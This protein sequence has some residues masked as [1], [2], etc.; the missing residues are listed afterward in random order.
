MP[1]MPSI[2]NN[3]IA[4]NHL[5]P[6]NYPDKWLIDRGYTPQSFA[7]I[8]LHDELCEATSK[9]INS[10]IADIAQIRPESAGEW[11]HIWP[12]SQNVNALNFLGHQKIHR[13]YSLYVSTRIAEIGASIP[14]EWKI[15]RILF[16]ATIKP[17]LKS[18]RFIVHS[19]GSY[20]WF[21]SRTNIPI[22]FA[23]RASWKLKKILKIDRIQ[24]DHSWPDWSIIAQSRAVRNIQSKYESFFPIFS[25]L[26]Y[27]NSAEE[28]LNSETMPSRMYLRMLQLL[29]IR[30]WHKKI[31]GSVF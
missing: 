10:F 20:P 27:S 14:R 30:G 24:S 11:L 31:A 13:H 6:D 22:R 17:L 1:L 7:R 25:K 4:A 26:F 28:V 2:I 23:V 8:L 19:N 5:P 3:C 12:F 21:G 16:H 15:N 29:I 18:T 9:R